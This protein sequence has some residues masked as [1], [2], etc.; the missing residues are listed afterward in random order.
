V[1]LVDV[2]DA[3]GWAEDHTDVLELELQ[4]V[5]L[6]VMLRDVFVRPFSDHRI[7]AYQRLTGTPSHVDPLTA[8][9]ALPRPDAGDLAV[10]VHS[11]GDLALLRTQRGTPPLEAGRGGIVQFHAFRDYSDVRPDGCFDRIADGFAETID[12]EVPLLS[13]ITATSASLATRFARPPLQ[14]LPRGGDTAPPVAGEDALLDR[15]HHLVHAAR[16]AGHQA[17]DRPAFLR[18][19]LRTLLHRADQFGRL[20]DVAEPAAV[21]IAS[22]SNGDRM[23]AVIAAHRRGIPALDVEH[24]YMGELSAYGRLGF[25]PP[26]GVTSVPSHFWC[27]GRESA[28]LLERSLGPATAAHRPVVG[29]APSYS[30]TDRAPRT[31]RPLDDEL[32]DRVSA[33]DRV[34]LFGWQPD[35]LVHDDVP[36][37]LPEALREAVV[38]AGTDV[39]FLLRL[40]PR[41]RHLVPLVER[42]LRRLGAT[43]VEVAGATH[44]D[45]DA[46]FAVTD[47]LLTSYSTVAFE[48]NRARIPVVLTDRIGHLMMGDYVER[49]LFHAAHDA[50]E[51]LSLVR[52]LRPDDVEVIEYVE[53]DPQA[54]RRALAAVL[55]A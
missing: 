15:V 28:R 9:P 33:A 32:A 19:R 12:G 40:H 7:R 10:D 43:N 29:G 18:D 24:G 45:L 23:A 3:I 55:G 17:E 14:L 46:L 4:G 54:P 27:W 48:A 34:A 13:V 30:P 16:A 35:M 37:L 22:F 36:D 26:T 42:E 53:T 47:V 20:L 21:Q 51:L 2:Y 39:L 49:G 8:G 31:P 41:S 5:N 52:N 1:N 6:W 11:F 50:E 38:R 25:V 44:A